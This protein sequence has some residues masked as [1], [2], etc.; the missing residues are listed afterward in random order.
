MTPQKMYIK[1]EELTFHT[2]QERKLYDQRL[3]I[4]VSRSKYNMTY[5]RTYITMAL[6][7]SPIDGHVTD[8]DTQ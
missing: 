2:N 8:F 1:V 7:R 5:T 4:S 6:Q 3:S